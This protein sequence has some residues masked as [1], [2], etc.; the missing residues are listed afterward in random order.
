[1]WADSRVNGKEY[2]YCPA[3]EGKLLAQTS[4]STKDGK[5][6]LELYGQEAT[7]LST[8]T[9]HKDKNKKK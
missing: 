1:M 6:Q 3:G 8:I 4:I 9:E 7:R 2:Q 5:L